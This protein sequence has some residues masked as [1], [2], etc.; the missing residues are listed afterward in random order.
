MSIR[1]EWVRYD[2]TSLDL[3]ISVAEER[4]LTR[5]ARIKHLAV[6]AVS[7]RITELEAQVGSALL[8]RNAR[9]VDLTPAGQS[10]LFYAR[11]VKQTSSVRRLFPEA[12]CFGGCINPRYFRRAVWSSLQR[13]GRHRA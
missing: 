12:Q 2:I 4:N 9:G 7:K 1:S 13:A 11:Q 10:L 5:A 6:S 8:I 3:F